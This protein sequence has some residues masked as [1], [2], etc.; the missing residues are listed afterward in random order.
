MSLGGLF[1]PVLEDKKTEHEGRIR[2]TKSQS[3][4]VCR[5]G[6]EINIPSVAERGALRPLG[7]QAK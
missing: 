5:G 1:E 6:R 4:Q 2:K 7:S 3:L